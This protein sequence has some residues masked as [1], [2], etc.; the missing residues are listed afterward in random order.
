MQ[1]IDPF[2]DFAA[3]FLANLC[4]ALFGVLLAFWIDRLRARRESRRLYGRVLQSCHFELMSLRV[5]LPYI[6]NPLKAGKL[7]AIR[8]SVSLPATR[9]AL[10]NP[11]VH[12]HA[13]RPLITVLNAISDYAG[14]NAE[15]LAGLVS[16]SRLAGDSKLASLE[17]VQQG[18]AYL[19][20]IVTDSMDRLGRMNELVLRALDE[21]IGH[22][23][24]TTQPDPADDDAVAQ[25]VHKILTE[26][27]E[28]FEEPKQDKSPVNPL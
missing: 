6:L 26:P 13:P 3:N 24:L 12:E 2:S 15:S 7:P 17:A 23:G 22:L 10:V 19:R 14:S 20:E 4:G 16:Q 27:F 5:L 9:G 21:E 8:L 11:L 1:P 28:P 25:G 18:V